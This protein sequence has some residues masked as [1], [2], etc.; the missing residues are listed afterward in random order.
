MK[1]ILIPLAALMVSSCIID[2]LYIQ[3]PGTYWSYDAETSSGHVEA[4]VIFEDDVHASV[5]QIVEDSGTSQTQHG[6]YTTDGHRVILSGEG[7]SNNIQF[8]RTFSHL[9]NNSTNRNMSPLKPKS[10]ES[11]AG[12]VWCTLEN[13]NMR[14]AM[15][16]DGSKC[17]QAGFKNVSH[18][19]GVPYGWEWK[20]SDYSLSGSHLTAGNIEATLFHDFMVVDTLGVFM[21]SNPFEENATNEL[22]N[23]VW[24]CGGVSS[25]P[26]L[27]IFTGTKTFT[28]ILVASKLIYQVKE[29]TYSFDGASI[30]F[31]MDDKQETCPLSGDRFT[32]YEKT[33]TRNS[34]PGSLP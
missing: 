10:W 11:M 7:W 23:T 26:G 14:V 9:K 33:F 2:P 17:L 22:K 18:E 16:P 25:Y 8:V 27:L 5:L 13:G 29:G 21:C 28:R 32:W 30:T 1:R 12:S 4:R 31:N 34:T 15:F 6:T 3:M 24:T 19:E 20:T